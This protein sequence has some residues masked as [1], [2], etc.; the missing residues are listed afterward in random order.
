MVNKSIENRNTKQHINNNMVWYQIQ[1]CK[2]S[3]DG[4]ISPSQPSALKENGGRSERTSLQRSMLLQQWGEW[5]IKTLTCSFNGGGGAWEFWKW[6]RIVK[7]VSPSMK[8]IQKHERMNEIAIWKVKMKE[9]ESF[10]FN[11]GSNKCYTL[12][13]MEEC[14]TSMDSRGK[15]HIRT[16]TC[17]TNICTL[18]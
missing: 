3:E 5:T 16:T 12:H 17:H 7:R 6:A 9:K 1:Q 8:M 4:R 13:P 10:E 11:Q 14:N 2:V 15:N 18:R